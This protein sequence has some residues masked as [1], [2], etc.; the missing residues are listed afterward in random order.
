MIKI[1]VT[2]EMIDSAISK[3]E[4]LG[5]IRDSITQGGGNLAGYLGE[6]AVAC[7]LGAQIVSN[8]RGRE[9]YN[10]DLVLPD[11]RRMEVK[12]KRRTVAPRSHYDVSV[13]KTSGHQRPDLYAFVSLEFERATKSHPKKYYGL[14]NA[15][16][17]G[18]MSAKVF[19]EGAEFWKSGRIDTSN[20]FK[21]HVDM[22]NMTISDISPALES[23]NNPEK[24]DEICASTCTLGV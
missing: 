14:R 3:A 9:K 11:G 24:A 8:D 2:Q 16:L 20:N 4:S 1:E 7:H 5:W 22:Y 23:L 13:A 17:C 18:Y 6:E 10:Y 12:T 21:T 19:W 15:W